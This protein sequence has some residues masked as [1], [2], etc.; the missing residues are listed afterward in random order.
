MWRLPH[1][2]KKKWLNDPHL[3]PREYHRMALVL[4]NTF[5]LRHN[6]VYL[7][8]HKKIRC[9]LLTAWMSAHMAA[10]MD[11]RSIVSTAVLYVS[12]VINEHYF[13]IFEIR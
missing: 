13:C 11:N 7:R 6:K 5:I 4:V 3:I 10:V 1:S 2:Y 12:I 9:F 8:Q